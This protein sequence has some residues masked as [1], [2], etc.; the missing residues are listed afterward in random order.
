LSEE[1][2]GWDWDS[3]IYIGTVLLN[4]KEE[5]I[6]RMKPRKYFALLKKHREFN[7]ISDTEEEKPQLAYAD[8]LF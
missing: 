7:T 4:R 8:K 3:I 2:K 5:E 1:D 6:W